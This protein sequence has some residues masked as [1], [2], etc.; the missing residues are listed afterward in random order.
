MSSDR[1]LVRT[2]PHG[3][4][5]G[6]IE[7]LPNLFDALGAPHAHRTAPAAGIPEA[8][9]VPVVTDVTPAGA[10]WLASAGAYPRSTRVLREDRS[11]AP[12]VLA[13]GSAFDVVNAPA[14]F[15]RLMLDRLWGEGPGTGPVAAH[16][17]RML[18][19]AAP[20][21]AQRL[22]WLLEWEERGSGGASDRG[23]AIPPLL[24][25]GTGDAVTV[26]A[27]ASAAPLAAAPAPDARTATPADPGAAARPDSRWLIAPDTRDPWLPGPEAL[28]WAAVRAA[29]SAAR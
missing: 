9:R 21:T 18:L 12:V 11:T 15:G 22:P 27:P 20:G 17:G 25:H 3:T 29:R 6:T 4:R 19:F 2:V 26:P 1:N 7:A 14:V 8:T 10:A 16:R 5:T 13:C 24:C 23:R 28:L